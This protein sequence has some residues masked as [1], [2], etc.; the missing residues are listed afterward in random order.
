MLVTTAIATSVRPQREIGRAI[1][2]P[3]RGT[4]WIHEVAGPPSAPVLVLLHGWS[5]TAELNWHPYLETLGRHFRVIAM[6]MRGH[7]RG[8]RSD[9]PFR[10]HECADDVA[11]LADQL[12]VDRCAVVGYSM[13]GAVGQLIWQRHP[14]LVDGLVFCSTSAAFRSNAR[15]RLLLR[16]AAG[17]SA[18]RATGPITSLTQSAIGALGR[19][20]RAGAAWGFEQM[21]L[22]DWGQLVEAGSEIGR[23]D[24][25]P[26]ISSIDVPTTVIVSSDDEVVATREQ[27]ALARSIPEATVRHLPGGHHRCVTHPEHF[28]PVLV[29]ACREVM[30]RR[31]GRAALDDV[32]AAS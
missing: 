26:W 32:A 4:T 8:I 13:G 23:H 31:A 24:A 22:H 17:A 12:G 16:A 7:G 19:L 11:A 18:V 10:L 6:D 2:L 14:S 20:D 3:G 9:G 28:G 29:A 5:A 21:A 30:A 25:R 27:V 1:T 15:V